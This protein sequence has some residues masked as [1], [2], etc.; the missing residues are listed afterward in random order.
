MDQN[1][2]HFILFLLAAN[3]LNHYV[4]VEPS[5]LYLE[6]GIIQLENENVREQTYMVTKSIQKNQVNKLKLIKTSNSQQ[7]EIRN[8][9]TLL[10]Y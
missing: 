9:V 2:I 1:V 4:L 6:S 3:G 8:F 5:H 7:V 10:V